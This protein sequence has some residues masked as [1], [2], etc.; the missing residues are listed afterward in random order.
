MS[1]TAC[2]LRMSGLGGSGGGDDG[3]G[4]MLWHVH[5]TRHGAGFPLHTQT[6][7]RL[8]GLGERQGCYP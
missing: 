8:G 4:F 6:C 1:F 5:T 2:V 3:G 7:K